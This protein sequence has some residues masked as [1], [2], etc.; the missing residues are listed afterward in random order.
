MIETLGTKHHCA[1]CSARFYDLN[2]SPARCPKCQTV[3]LIPADTEN[4]APA[5]EPEDT[6]TF[7]EDIS[8]ESMDPLEDTAELDDGT[9]LRTLSS[10]QEPV[11][12][13]AT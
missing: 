5:P 11:L 1:S 12:E 9:D 2:Q 10:T 3:S 8:A 4:K 13:E 6:D 7:T